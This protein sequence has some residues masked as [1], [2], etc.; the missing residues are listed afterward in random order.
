MNLDFKKASK[1]LSLIGIL[2]IL[3]N[4]IAYFLNYVQISTSL[5][6]IFIFL[7]IAFVYIFII[8]K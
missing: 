4:Y 2:A 7:L 3:F 1:I 5:N 8:S 6:I